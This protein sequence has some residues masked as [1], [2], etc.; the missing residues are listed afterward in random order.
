MVKYLLIDQIL[1]VWSRLTV[2]RS[3]SSAETLIE[4]TES[5]WPVEK[6]WSKLKSNR[7]QTL[8]VC[9]Q[10]VTSILPKLIKWPFDNCEKEQ[11]GSIQLTI[12]MVPLLKP[13]ATRS[14]A[15]TKTEH[16]AF[17]PVGIDLMCFPSFELQTIKFVK[18][19]ILLNT[20]HQLPP[21]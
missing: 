18:I 14:S 1:I 17:N 10:L 3:F 9:A 6:V 16:T 2:A 11:V 4:S 5:A 13:M 15:K 19:Q 8:I 20:T 12:L 7:F 21:S